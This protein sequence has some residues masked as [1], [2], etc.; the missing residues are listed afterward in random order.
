MLSALFWTRRTTPTAFHPTPL[1]SYPGGEGAPV[2][3]PDGKQVAFAWTGPE[4]DNWDVYLK[5]IGSET[6][7]R[8]TDDPAFE[9]QPAWSPDGS[10]VAFMRRSEEGCWIYLV[11]ALGGPA[12]K[13]ASCG[14]SI[15]GDLA[16]SPDGQWLAFNDRAAPEEPFRIF[17]LAPDRKRVV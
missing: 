4:G 8:L 11:A 13:L 3:S 2:L 12:R 5:L 14:A 6:P 17:L 1:T 9:H 7:L 16:W 10:Q 15:Y